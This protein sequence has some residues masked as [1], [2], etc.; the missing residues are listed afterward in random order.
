MTALRRFAWV[1]AVAT[2]LILGS[3]DSA[4]SGADWEER[5]HS[6]TDWEEIR[7]GAEGGDAEAQIKL[8][9]AHLEDDVLGGTVA[10]QE[11]DVQAYLW[12][13]LGVAG[14]S[15]ADTD[16]LMIAR[17]FAIEDLRRLEKRMT[18]L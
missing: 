13:S 14:L 9:N 5:V 8:G 7:R 17:D 1:A 10:L 16:T 12:L 4:H 3:F 15:D 18:P 11:D 2:A 6:D